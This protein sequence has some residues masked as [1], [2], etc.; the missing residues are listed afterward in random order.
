MRLVSFLFANDVF[1]SEFDFNLG[2][3]EEVCGQFF[4]PHVIKDLPT[5]FQPFPFVDLLL[6]KFAV[7][8]CVSMVLEDGIVSWLNK[9][10][11]MCGIV[12]HLLC[13]FISLRESVRI[14]V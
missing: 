7:E 2:H 11:I 6:T 3:S 1:A 4:V 10:C 14:F 13:S 5:L 8:A 9:S 12:L